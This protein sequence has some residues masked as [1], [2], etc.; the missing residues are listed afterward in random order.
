[1]KSLPNIN[2]CTIAVIGLGYVGLPVAVEF[3]KTT[4]SVLSKKKLNRKIIG[5]DINES[6]INKLKEGIDTTKEIESSTLNKIKN[7][8]YTTNRFDLAQ[9][10]V[11]IVTVPTPIDSEKTPELSLLKKACEITKTDPIKFPYS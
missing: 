11:Y 7:I 5:F 9:A 2:E 10:D 4:N 6:R 1:M 8:S 3:A